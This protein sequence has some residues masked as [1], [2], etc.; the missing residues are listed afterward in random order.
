[1][2]LVF[3]ITAQIEHPK[4]KG[5]ITVTLLIAPVRFDQLNK[6]QKDESSRV[7]SPLRNIPA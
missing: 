4:A 7:R 1:M 5:E 6:H 3:F 2:T